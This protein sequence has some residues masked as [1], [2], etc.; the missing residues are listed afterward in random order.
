MDE[1]TEICELFEEYTDSIYYAGYC[2][3]M[4]DEMPERYAHELAEF[5]QTAVFPL[6]Y[7]HQNL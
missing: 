5:K 6:V 2:A 7:N 3:Q 4:R 1:D